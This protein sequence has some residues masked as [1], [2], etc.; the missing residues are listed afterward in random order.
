MR[1]RQDMIATEI[2]ALSITA[3]RRIRPDKIK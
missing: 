3:L 2:T 1:V